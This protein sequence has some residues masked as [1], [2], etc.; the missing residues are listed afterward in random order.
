MRVNAR[1]GRARG[2][3]VASSLLGLD[4]AHCLMQICDKSRARILGKERFGK[5]ASSRDRWIAGNVR[6]LGEEG[7]VDLL[8]MAFI[9]PEP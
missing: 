3:I 1:L 2:R 9:E 7:G 6:L 4:L 5:G 8:K